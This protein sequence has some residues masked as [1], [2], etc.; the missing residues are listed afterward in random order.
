M[1]TNERVAKT[2]LAVMFPGQQVPAHAV[3]YIAAYM[4]TGTPKTPRKRIKRQRIAAR[5]NVAQDHLLLSRYESMQLATASAALRPDPGISST[6]VQN[7]KR[8]NTWP[9]S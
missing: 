7:T 6:R 4:L 9:N 5:Y 1:N 8:G 2:F 3:N